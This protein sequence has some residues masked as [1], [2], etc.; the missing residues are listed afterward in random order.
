LCAVGAHMYVYACRT[1]ALR[2]AGTGS[3]VQILDETQGKFK[4]FKH[5]LKS[6]TA[7]DGTTSVKNSYQQAHAARTVVLAWVRCQRKSFLA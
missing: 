5:M 6:D 2:P 7:F 3:C 1:A 4:G